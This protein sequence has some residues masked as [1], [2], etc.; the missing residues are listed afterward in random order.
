MLCDTGH[1]L[2]GYNIVL[3]GLINL[4]SIYLFSFLMEELFTFIIIEY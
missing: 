1:I 3:S 2:L 4:N